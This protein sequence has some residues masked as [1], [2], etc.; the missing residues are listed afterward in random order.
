MMIYIIYL[1][2]SLNGLYY[3]KVVKLNIFSREKLSP[4]EHQEKC[5]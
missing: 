4:K 5:S 2:F 1:L 3:Y